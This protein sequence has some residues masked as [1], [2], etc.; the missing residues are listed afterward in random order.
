[1]NPEDR[2]SWQGFLDLLQPPRGYKLGAA[3]GTTFGLSPE[4]LVAALLSMA[5]ADGEALASDP[6]AAAMA[7]TRMSSRVSVLVHPAT[8]TGPAGASPIRL[9]AL[10]DRLV[11]EVQP[12]RGL[13]HPKVWALRFELVGAGRS[14]LPK[15]IG[16]VL[17]G[18]RN[19][20][21]SNCFE[22]GMVLEGYTGTGETS[23]FSKDV[24]KALRKWYAAADSVLPNAVLALPS[25]LDG[26]Q[27]QTPLE[28]EEA[29]RLRWQGGEDGGLHKHVP[30]E[31][32]RAVLVSPFVE[33]DFLE[34]LVGRTTGTLSVVSMPETLDALPQATIDLLEQRAVGQGCPVLYHVGAHGDPEDA[35]LD[36]VHAK[37]LLLEDR[38]GAPVTFIGSA[39]ATG[40]GW[41]LGGFAN[42]EAVAEARP[43]IGIDRFVADFIR[44]NKTATH[45]WV[46]EY[47]RDEE[48]V[49]DESREAERRVLAALRE[50]A[51]IKPL[52]QYDPEQRTLVADARSTWVLLPVWVR[53]GYELSFTPLLLSNRTASWRPLAELEQGPCR[54]ENVELSDVSAFVLLRA[55][56]SQP[57]IEKQ[58]L[59]V[60]RLEMTQS[61]LDRR[62]DL[63]RSEILATADPVDI[64]N[65]LVRGLAHFKGRQLTPGPRG[66]GGAGNIRAILGHATLER[67]LH[68]IAADPS[69]LTEMRQLLGHSHGDV[70]NKL[71]DE[72]ESAL[73]SVTAEAS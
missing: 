20:S 6:V 12:V 17:V 56:G 63:I 42:V 40:P 50:A 11:K 23:A 46:S 66:K 27:M 47:F 52:L 53:E 36:G 65:A 35:F 33:P 54:F 60:G 51:R 55:R 16:R 45:P 18:S 57:L 4:A 62:D 7:I 3:V 21:A 24:A 71:F 26:L 41:G 70:L 43:G 48:V 19:L 49:I 28:A 30:N 38:H 61:A 2:K 10:L 73:K 29:L 31:C 69:L 44:G 8:M 25:F 32:S 59:L 34:F 64:L 13:F 58:R 22:A 67:L 5:D 14:D 72:L 39:N 37:L 68:A 9:V 1:M 15:E